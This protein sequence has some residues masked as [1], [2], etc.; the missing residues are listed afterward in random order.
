MNVSIIMPTYNNTKMLASTLAAFEKVEFPVGSE[1]IIVNNNSTDDTANTVKL[2]S[3]R[4]PIVYAF[5]GKKGVS[6]AKN[7]GIGMAKGELLIFTDDDVRP[8]PSWIKAYVSAY[9]KNPRGYFWGGPIESEFQGQKP[10]TRLL[11]FAPPSVKGLT[12]GS[13]ERLL[14]GNEWLAGANWACPADVFSQ[15]GLFDDAVG[16]YPDAPLVLTGEETDLQRRLKD[17]GYKS[18]YLPD[19]LLLHVVPPQKCTLKHVANRAEATGRNLRRISPIKRSAKML[20]GVPLWRY[21]RCIE[22]WLRAWAKRIVGRD[23]YPDYITYRMDKGFL[24]GM[25]ESSGRK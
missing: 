4:L 10:D 17:I 21:R 25:P 19:V 9:Q 12:F 16:P 15:V 18:L 11:K 6:S 13:K 24:I 3:K 14:G 22:S 1:L 8:V 20:R 23:W 7:R 5:E 2:F